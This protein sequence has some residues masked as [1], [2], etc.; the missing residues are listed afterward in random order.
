MEIAVE[1]IYAVGL[2]FFIVQ[3]LRWFQNLIRYEIVLF[4]ASRMKNE[5]AYLKLKSADPRFAIGFGE[6]SKR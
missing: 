2:L 4:R 1:N 6:A 3:R 5:E